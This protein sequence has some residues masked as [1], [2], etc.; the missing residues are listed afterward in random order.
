VPQ[1][2]LIVDDSPTVRQQLRLC[3]ET[4]GYKV[5][6]A[7][8]GKLGLEAADR[9]TVSM[10]ISDINMPV[11]NGIDFIR[12]LRK[13]PTYQKT[14]VFVLTTE[15]GAANAQAGKEAGA[16]V[17]IVKPFKPEILLKGIKRVI[18]D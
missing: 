1:S 17:W 7:I 2:I 6:E 18:G 9:N 10:V 11:M 4:G 3:L 13:R 8:N 5:V 15:S 16:T 12:E 14:P